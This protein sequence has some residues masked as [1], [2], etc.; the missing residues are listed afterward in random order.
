MLRATA[1]GR[2]RGAVALEDDLAGV[3]DMVTAEAARGN[4]YATRPSRGAAGVGGAARRAHRVPAGRVRTTRR[5]SR[6]IAS[7]GF[8]T[9]YTYHYRGVPGERSMNDA[10]VA[11]AV[12]LGRRCSAHGL[13]VA[14]AESCT[15]GLV[16]GA[17]TDVAGSSGWFERGFV[18]YS[19]EAKIEMLGVHADT[20]AAHGAVSEATAAEMAA[21]ALAS[22]R[23]DLAVAVTGVAGPGRRVGAASPWGPSASPGRDAARAASAPRRDTF[24]GDRAAVRAATVGRWHCKGLHRPLGLGRQGLASNDR[25]MP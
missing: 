1:T 9:L 13:C 16:A 3:Y 6:C 7:F 22:S 4:G 19:N 18:T 12:A 5:R 14:T 11:L 15:G 25:S 24:R 17:I 2:L 10:Y 8:A 23:A 21:G 20:L